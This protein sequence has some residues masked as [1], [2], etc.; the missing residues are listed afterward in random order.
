V[1]GFFSRRAVVVLRVPCRLVLGAVW[2]FFPAKPVCAFDVGSF[3]E[4]R[5]LDLPA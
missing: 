1:T 3:V 2:C 4:L 5:G